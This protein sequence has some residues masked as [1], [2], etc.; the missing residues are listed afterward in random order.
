MKKAAQQW[1]AFSFYVLEKNEM[2]QSLISSS[3]VSKK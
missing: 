1:A 2:N 3:W